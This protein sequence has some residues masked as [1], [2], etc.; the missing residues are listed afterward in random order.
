MSKIDLEKERKASAKRRA[1]QL[2]SMR[3]EKPAEEQPTR[4]LTPAER[5]KLQD[6]DYVAP[7]D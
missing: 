7:K 5:R 6:E 4:R 1:R 3:R 2:E